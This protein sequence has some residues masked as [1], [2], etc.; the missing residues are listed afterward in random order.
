MGVYALKF[1]VFAV[2]LGVHPNQSSIN[3]IFVTKLLLPGRFADNKFAD[4]TIR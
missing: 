3:V 1:G 4:K 2:N